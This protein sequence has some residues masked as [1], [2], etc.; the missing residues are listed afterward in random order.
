[1]ANEAKYWILAN[2]AAKAIGWLPETIFTQWAW[3]TAHFTSANLLKN[4]NIAGQTWTKANPMSIRGTARPANEGGYYIKYSDAAQ[5][6]VDFIKKNHRYDG[7]KNAKTVEAQIDAIA[8]AGW[9]ADKN[10]AVGLKSLHQSNIKHG[11]YKLP[12]T[13]VPKPVATK[14]PAVKVAESK[15]SMGLKAIGKIKI[16][17]VKHAAYIVD[18][19]SVTGDN[20]TTIGRGAVIEISGS[21]PGWWE[22]IYNGKRAYVKAEY[23]KKI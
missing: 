23:A 12:S 19:P 13:I 17:E 8:K 18:R 3:E 15:A 7:V 5:G 11:Y 6:Y 9:A 2:K 16:V 1:M 14:K 10:Y 4:N 21:V 20:L 22:V